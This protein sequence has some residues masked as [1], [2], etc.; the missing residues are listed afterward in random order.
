MDSSTMVDGNQTERFFRTIYGANL[1]KVNW[2]GSPNRKSDGKIIPKPLGWLPPTTQVIDRILQTGENPGREMF[3]FVAPMR[4]KNEQD[5][6]VKAEDALPCPVVWVDIDREL[7]DDQQA[8]LERLDATTVASG[9]PGKIHAYVPLTEPQPRHIVEALNKGLIRAFD[10][11][12]KQSAATLLRVPGSWHRKGEPRRCQVVRLSSG[13]WDAVELAAELGVSLTS[14]RPTMRARKSVPT[15]SKPIPTSDPRRK[16]VDR[17]L[18]MSNQRHEYG[19]SRYLI[20]YQLIIGCIEAKVTDLAELLW[21]LEQSE[22]ARDKVTE[23]GGTIREHLTKILGKPAI[24]EKIQAVEGR[25]ERVIPTPSDETGSLA[26]VLRLPREAPSVA[27]KEER[28]GEVRWAL[29]F[30]DRYRGEI[31]HTPGRGWFEWT[32]FGWRSLESQHGPMNRVIELT[33]E[34]LWEVPTLTDSDARDELSADVRRAEKASAIRGI[35]TLASTLPGIARQDSE[36]DDRP[37]LFAVRNGVIDLLTD[38]FRPAHPDDLITRIAGCDYDPDAACPRYDR[39]MGRWQPDAEMRAYIHRIGGSALQGRPTEQTLPVFYGSGANGKG[40]TVNNAWLP[41][42]GH[43]GMVIGVEVLLASQSSGVYLPQKAS[44][45]GRRFVV[46]SEPGS[47]AKF[48]TGTL[49]LLTGGDPIQA[50]AKYKAPMQV[51]PTWQVVMLTNRRPTPPASDGAVWRRLRAVPWDA[52][53]PE[54]EWNTRL[55]EELG[56][57]LPGILNRLLEGWRDYRD[58]GYD[59]QVPRIVRES[60][61]KWREEVDT[62]GQFIADQC[63]VGSQL[64]CLSSELYTEWKDWCQKYGEEAGSNKAFTQELMDRGY[65]VKRSSKGNQI[66]GLM[67]NDIEEM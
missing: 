32:D 47:G 21:I 25:G 54:G 55:P 35:L 8:R 60:T 61:S 51:K 66:V 38:E 33:Q 63:T 20:M 5:N 50:C 28:R 11:D 65:T 16:R 18:R 1:P 57:E 36:L 39:Y 13:R 17:W 34:A 14:E 37:D 30:A 40:S 45:A 24:A 48:A 49:K 12:H 62:H 56:A 23:E 52:A 19:D 26:A 15:E 46:T 10:G 64:K 59:I 44:L 58:H 6:W 9:G 31:M 53:I 42:F 2:I 67:P 43:Y 41:V 4:R 27:V 7:T 3:F 29:R 22:T